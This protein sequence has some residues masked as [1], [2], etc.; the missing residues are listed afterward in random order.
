MST[1][2]VSTIGWVNI[3]L[4][5]RS[6]REVLPATALLGTMAFSISYLMGFVFPRI[7]ERILER[8]GPT[9]AMLRFRAAFLG[10]EAAMALPG[11]IAA[12]IHWSHPV[13]LALFFAQIIVVCTRV[14]AGETER[15]TID[16]LL[17]LPVSRWQ[18]Y[19]SETL[20]FLFTGALMLLA[21]AGGAYLSRSSVN[22]KVLVDWDGVERVLVN[23]A[24]LQVAFIGLVCLFS[25]LSTRRGRAVLAG[26]AVV[27]VWIIG[28]FLGGL[29]E[30]ARSVEW[31][32]AL[33]YYKPLVVIRAD[34]LPVG[35]CLVLLGAG[36]VAWV[37]GGVVLSRRPLTSL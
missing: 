19:A 18:I 29:W 21:A 37:A 17:G 11:Q 28:E 13:L 16:V 4:V 24:C 3:G 35:H 1:R 31:L 26:V 14:P 30:P 9:A 34:E 23:L 5:Q 8:G 7:Q 2:L 36:L 12:G 22:E 10:D 20:V 32:S 15:G 25:T 33:H 6:L 27:L